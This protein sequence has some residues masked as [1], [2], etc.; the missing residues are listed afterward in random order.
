[1]PNLI[2]AAPILD[3]VAAFDAAFFG[4]TPREAE[5]ID[6]QHRIF[7]E[8]AW[9]ALEHAGYELGAVQGL[10]RSVRRRRH[11]RLPAE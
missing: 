4:Y 11:Q 9:E 6:P 2:K 5:L 1:M 8:C 3:D 10:D 7:L